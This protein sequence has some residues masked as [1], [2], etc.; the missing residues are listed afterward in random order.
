[1]GFVRRH[2]AIFSERELWR[3]HDG[4]TDESQAL[5]CRILKR[6]WLRDLSNLRVKRMFTLH[7]RIA[8]S[9]DNHHFPVHENRMCE[10]VIEFQYN[11][12][13]YIIEFEQSHILIQR[14]GSQ[15]H[16]TRHADRAGRLHK[17][18]ATARALYT[19]LN[20]QKRR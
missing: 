15:S 1:M 5:G 17:R 4:V 20:T 6:F 3:A 2:L 11:G 16:M 18:A 10:H 12:S 19:Q 9:L 7:L 8:T 14:P 13:L